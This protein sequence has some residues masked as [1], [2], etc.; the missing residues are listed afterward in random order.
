MHRKYG[1]LPQKTAIT[2]NDI[3]DITD[4]LEAT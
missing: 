3:E 4:E 1:E 2:E